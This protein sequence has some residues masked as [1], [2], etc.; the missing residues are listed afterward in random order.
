MNDKCKSSCCYGEPAEKPDQL[1]YVKVLLECSFKEAALFYRR[2]AAFLI[3]NVAGLGAAGTFVADVQKRAL[4][5][6][7]GL[8]KA[9]LEQAQARALHAVDIGAIFGIGLCFVWMF[10]IYSSLWMNHVWIGAAKEL[11]SKD[12]EAFPDSFRKA[13]LRT[14]STSQ[15]NAYDSSRIHVGPFSGIGATLHYVLALGFGIAWGLL[16]V[17]DLV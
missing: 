4:T 6:T 11:V 15:I 7:E 14:P 2:T 10:A 17:G 16:L 12:E 3:I 5:S 9:E 8:V 1:E 13:L